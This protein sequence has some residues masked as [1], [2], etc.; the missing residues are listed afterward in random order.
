MTTSDLIDHHIEQATRRPNPARARLRES[1]V[2]VWTLVAQLPTVDGDVNRL[3]AAYD[4]PPSA[5][6]AAL[7]YYQ[8][9]RELID[10]Q[11]ALN[12]A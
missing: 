10:A 6:E 12:A 8:L 1:G 2:E 7:A 4:L 9:H 5:V 11:I 3:A